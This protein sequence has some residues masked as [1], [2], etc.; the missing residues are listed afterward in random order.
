MFRFH[1]RAWAAVLLAVA[2]VTGVAACG[3]GEHGGSQAT[4]T[5]KSSPEGGAGV[6]MI[7]LAAVE[8]A[9]SIKAKGQDLASGSINV[10]TGD[11][12]GDGEADILVGAPQADGPRGA[13]ADAGEAYV[14]FGPLSGAHEAKDADVTIYGA[15]PGDSLGFSVL[16]GDLNGDDVDDV[17]VG[18]PGVTA[19]FDPRSDQGRVYVFY[20]GR[21]LEKTKEFDLAS[22]V[23]DFT[24]TGAEGFSRAGNALAMGDIN[25]DG[26]T[27]LIVGAPFAGRKPGTAPGGERTAVGEVYVIFGGKEL[28][29]EL[30][31][32]ATSPDLILSGPEALGQFGSAVATGDVN[33]DGI[34][35]VIVSAHRSGTSFGRPEA[36]AVY[37]FFGGKGVRGKISVQEGGQNATLLGPAPSAG[38]GFPLAVIDFNGDGAGDIAAGGRS[39]GPAGPLTLGSVR[40]IF[41]GKDIG[42]ETDLAQTPADV[43]LQATSPTDLLPTSLAAGD[44]DG[45]GT[46]DLAIGSA[47]AE[48]DGRMGAGKVY[49]LLGRHSLG[50]EAD[51]SSMAQT[52]VIGAQADERLGSAIAIGSGPG[53]KPSLFLTAPGGGSGTKDGKVY[54]VPVGAP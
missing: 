10:A 38:F 12:N 31:V 52:V 49:V 25:G 19:G 50:G 23:Y 6:L 4:S 27:D 30:N 28:S 29:G 20:G 40:I 46:G 44:G 26:K 22:D 3:G 5:P 43:L 18:A 51:I 42:G 17:I 37:V 15:L 34:D 9:F 1:A 14:F 2:V 33:D 41:G 16:A 47:L 21:D 13:R 53:S 24:L 48:G 45:D 39:D 7:D 8:P 35:D 32:A 11:F 36:G 54:V